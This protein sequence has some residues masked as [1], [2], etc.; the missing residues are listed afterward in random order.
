[1]YL[2]TCSNYDA[3]QPKEYNHKR[4]AA[5]WDFREYPWE[6][7]QIITLCTA[8]GVSGNKFDN[9]KRSKDHWLG[10]YAIMLDFDNGVVTTDYLLENQDRWEF[11]SY[12]FSSQ[13]HQKTKSGALVEEQACDRLRVLIPLEE[14]IKDAAHLEAVKHA[15]V[16]QFTLDGESALDQSCLDQSRYFAH[17]TTAVSSFVE[18]QGAMDWTTIPGIKDKPR[19][20]TMSPSASVDEH[21]FRLESTI[22]DENENMVPLVDLEP[23]T[24]VYCPVCGDAPYRSNTTQRN[25]YYFLND[26]GLP[27]IYCHSCK[28]REMGVSGDGIYTLHP[29]DIMKYK[30]KKDEVV[31]FIDTL[32]SQFLGGCVE[33]GQTEFVVRPLNAGTHVTQF[34][35]SHKIPIPEVFPRARYEM[36]F[37][38]DHVINFDGGYVNKYIAP[39]VLRTPVP[40]GHTPQCPPTINK[41]LRHVTA[42]DRQILE[43]L[44]NNLAH[45]VQTREK[46]IVS[47]L[48]Q[49]VEGTGKGFLFDQIISPMFGRNYCAQTDQDAF[50]N[51]FNSFLTENVFVLVN[52]VS[53]DFVT[54]KRK[55]LHTIEK[56]KTAITDTRVQI[57][58]KGQDRYNGLN[59]CSFIFATN[60]R[61]GLILAEDDRRFNVAPRQ[62]QKIQDMPW[63]QGY[64]TMVTIVESELQEFVWYLKQY[65]VDEA[66]TVEVMN[67]EP[68]RM[69]QSLSKTGAD[70]FFER[71]QAG[72]LEWIL[73]NIPKSGEKTV[74]EY[75][76]HSLTF[77]TL[78][79]TLMK[80]NKIPQKTLCALYNLINKKDLSVEMYGR[81]AQEHGMPLPKTIRLG[82]LVDWGIAIDWQKPANLDE[83]N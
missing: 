38:S 21:T 10:T 7:E 17:G 67:N 46:M 45:L 18:G 13:N 6:E 31:V 19:S 70:V 83:D 53:G 25:A 16:D 80:S 28:S 20:S 69:L 29:D 35:K 27:A 76:D 39:A 78:E 50:G 23:D 59:Q 22:K 62:E 73:N 37:H 43:H 65:D 3:S 24:A 5:G 57:E 60:R 56:M 42:G 82:K 2:S 77:H 1:M 44:V 54:T 79:D 58:E 71:V 30:Y 33:P 41:I 8:R 75:S 52:E 51:Q 4:V 66:Q 26:E 47:Y 40:T 81:L 72:D 48:F 15:L 12:V 55:N 49:G 14:P 9:G 68:K 63:W 74:I 11:D 34:C 61:H 32:N 36:K 64:E